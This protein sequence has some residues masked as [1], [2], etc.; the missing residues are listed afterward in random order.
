MA[1][2]VVVSVAAAFFLLFRWFALDP[3]ADL[4][5]SLP[6]GDD[7]PAG[8][9][10]S[11]A[12]TN[13]EGTFEVFGGTAAALPGA[14]PRFRGADFDNIRKEGPPL[15]D[16]WGEGGPPVL[17]SVEL[18]EGHAGAAV[19]NGRVYVLDYDEAKRADAIRCFS[20]ADGAEIWR[21]SYSVAMKRNHGLS[22]TVP[23]VTGEYVITIG[24]RCHTVCLK[25]DTG[26]FVWGIDMVRDY[27]TTEP[28][29]YTGQCPLIDNGCAVLAP[30]G[31]DALLMGVELATGN[32]AWKTP[33]P[34]GYTMSHS[35]VM[36]MTLLGA[37]MYVYA[38][39]GAV[40]GVA[41]D[42]ERAGEIL[43][44]APWK[45]RVIAPSPVAVGDDRILMAAGY[46]EGSIMLRLLKT[47]EAFSVEK[48]YEKSPKDGL[49]CEQ[50]T[51]IH[52]G[53]LLYGIMPK[54]AGA[55]KEQ[56]V[57]Y[58]PDGHLL[59]SSGAENR[60][61]LGPFLLADDKF[62]VLSDDGVLTLLRASA[63]AYL[64][65]DQARVLDGHDAWGPMALVDTRLLLRD[66]KRMICIDVGQ[67]ANPS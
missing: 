43:W 41:A 27:G 46:G 66:S 15:A 48:V 23:A 5:V 12:A 16:G 33:N 18:G 29:W 6:G 11:E 49:T 34:K 40:V 60:F 67:G 44:E 58:H 57:C 19:L 35:S 3:A 36:P 32:V 2:T 21:R 31:P 63:E 56:F 14:W 47:G 42:G 22:R 54:D 62:Y 20:L 10:L 8:L 1:L 39:L 52:A 50:Q 65:L 24:P 53:G 7:R 9:E 55:L 61:G 51:P 59:W 45:P 64:Q 4:A 37:R 17:W 13:L 38:A 30:G 28:L 25:A 26:E